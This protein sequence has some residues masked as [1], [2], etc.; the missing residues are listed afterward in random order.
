MMVGHR[1]NHRKIADVASDETLQPA[2]AAKGAYAPSSSE[3][4]SKI[5]SGSI[6]LRSERKQAARRSPTVNAA[7]PL[8]LSSIVTPKLSS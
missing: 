6:R 8:G 1:G 3:S 7:R 5:A 4:L 2:Q